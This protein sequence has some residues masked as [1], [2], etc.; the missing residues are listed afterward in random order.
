MARRKAKKYLADTS[1]V[2]ALIG[3]SGREHIEHVA[4]EVQDATLWAS[5][6]IRME[7]IK[8][9]V[10]DSI[11]MALTI[12][13]C[14]TMSDA[15]HRISQDFRPRRVKACMALIAHRLAQRGEFEETDTSLIA[16]EMGSDA[17]QLLE[18]FDD[19]FRSRIPNNCHC[20]IGGVALEVN[21]DDMFFGLYEFYQKLGEPIE[22]CRI[23]D[24][25]G[26][27]GQKTR[28]EVVLRDPLAKRTSACKNLAVI[29]EGKDPWIDCRN[30]SKIGDLVIAL[31]QP[32]SWELLHI[33]DSFNAL[34][35]CLGKNHKQ[36]ESLLGLA[37]RD[38]D[39]RALE[40]DD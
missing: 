10:L 36:L 33:D 23:N 34:C 8:R 25:V 2:P 37:H 32:A 19:V 26:I 7:F 39:P 40:L 28:V 20:E 3:V 15:L 6:Y 18:E 35:A 29:L 14:S 5:V 16:E 11:W 31:E 38:L 12:K 13:Q 22:D 17:V 9:F 24:Y 27:T 21:Y 1:V 4:S 30:C